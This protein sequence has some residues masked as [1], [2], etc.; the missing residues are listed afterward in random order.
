MLAHGV[1]NVVVCDVCGALYVERPG[2]DPIHH[3]LATATNP[4]DERGIAERCSRGPTFLVG[5]SRP[6]AVSAAAI[7][8]MAARPV[9]FVMANR[10]PEVSVEAVAP[11][12]AVVATGRS[13]YPNQINIVL[14]FP[15]VF[16]G[17]LDLRAAA[18]SNQMKLA[19]AHTLA[20]QVREDELH[21][22]ASSRA[23]SI[24]MSLRPSPGRSRMRPRPVA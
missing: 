22:N 3:A 12:V 10:Q 5:V 11:H 2:L 18:I 14:A 16:R 24:A 4:Y 1:R 20:A 21:A 19:A 13:D 7:R 23:S 9:V 15:G 17:A 6:G 8:K